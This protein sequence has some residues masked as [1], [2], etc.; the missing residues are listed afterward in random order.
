MLYRAGR[1]QQLIFYTAHLDDTQRM[2]FTTLLLEEVL[3]WTRKQ[4]GTSNLRAL[5]YF[6]EV[7]GYLPPTA[8]PPSK[9]PLLTLLKQARAFGVGILLATQNPMDLDYK[10]LSNAGTWFVGKLQT[11]RDKARLLEGM[12]S[13][14]AE[15]GHLTNRA[16]LD[17][18]ISSLGN[19]IFLLHDIHRPE[20]ILFQSRWSL[21]FLRG[22]LT[23][24][25]V[26][27]L[28]GPLK[29]QAETPAPMVILLCAHCGAEL[30][31]DVTDRCL[32]CGQ[33]PW[34]KDDFR[35]QDKAFRD[36]LAR[37]TAPVAAAAAKVDESVS[38][39]PPVLPPDVKQYYLMPGGR[40]SANAEVRYR[41]RVLGVAEVVY[42][43]DK[44]K[45]K[46]HTQSV[47]LL[48]EP[49]AAGHPTA[50]DKAVPFAGDVVAESVKNARW[51]RAPEALDTGRKVKALEKAFIDYLYSSRKLS[52]F[53]NRALGLVSEPGETKEAFIQRCRAAAR[54]QAEQ[55]RT[56][57]RVKFKPRFEALDMKLPANE[58]PQQKPGAS[59][60]SWIIAAPVADTT[61]D[62]ANPRQVEKR[63]K[64]TADYEAKMG[65]IQE[66]WRRAGDEAVPIQVKPRK[67]DVR[68]THFG[69]GWAPG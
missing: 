51:E 59:W 48:A 7:F 41:P 68:V 35:L 4:A 44:R 6:D 12:E 47:R 63:R 52:L 13:A 20:P 16:H 27:T 1:P 56:M 39:Q 49:A 31:P 50:W 62:D 29:K 69:I 46:E 45:G 36:G 11:D 8:N 5:L 18:V 67:T 26:G 34:A 37:P 40:N 66:K 55:A 15:H 28:M 42:V 33:P 2:F 64:L 14:A 3:S 65:E 43:L 38:R 25:Q 17:S 32:K 19:R 61:D 10:A 24:E 21:S 23:R 58:K 9:R 54:E 60:L 30:S 57:E 53:E 22:P